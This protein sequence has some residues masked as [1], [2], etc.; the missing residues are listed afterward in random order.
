[1][2]R[3][4]DKAG[5][6][7]EITMTDIR[8]GCSWE[9]DFFEVGGLLLDAD[10]DAYIVEDVDYLIDQVEDY[11]EGRGDFADEQPGKELSDFEYSIIPA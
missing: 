11:M 3:F 9:R 7:A 4:I 2:T 6:M 5:C 8:T 1:M 10:A